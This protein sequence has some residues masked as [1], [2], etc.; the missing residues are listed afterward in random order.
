[1]G[2]CIYICMCVN[3]CLGASMYIYMHA[4]FVLYS[5]HYNAFSIKFSERGVV[6]SYVGAHMH[7]DMSAAHGLRARV[8]ACVC[9]RVHCCNIY[10]Y[11]PVCCMHLCLC[12]RVGMH[13]C[14]DV[15]VYACMYA[16][17]HA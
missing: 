2:A 14:M 5:L 10:V 12:V 17:V 8:R 1:M 3:I 11:I 4:W 6:R 16:G 13:V 7:K 15:C 9:T